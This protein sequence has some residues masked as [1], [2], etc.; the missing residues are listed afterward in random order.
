[1]RVLLSSEAIKR[2]VEPSG[3]MEVRL[4]MTRIV[5]ELGAFVEGE[6]VFEYPYKEVEF[7][8]EGRVRDMEGY[9]ILF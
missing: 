7:V 5:V 6:F 9:T 3:K 2:G 8:A 4:K 1:M